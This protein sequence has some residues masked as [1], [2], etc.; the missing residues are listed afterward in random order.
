MNKRV[1]PQSVLGLFMAA[2]LVLATMGCSEAPAAPEGQPPKG[3]LNDSILA[4]SMSTS[5]EEAVSGHGSGQVVFMDDAGNLTSIE[6]TGIDGAQVEAGD[7]KLFFTD[8]QFDYVLTKELDKYRHRHQQYTQE[9]LVA[10]EGPDSF[11]A[12]FNSNYS[13]DGSTYQFDISSGT[14]KDHAEY[15]VNDYFELLGNCG[16]EIYGVAVDDSKADADRAPRNLVQLYPQTDGKGSTGTWTPEDASQQFGWEVPCQ[17]QQLH[18]LSTE[19]M[20][21]P[22]EQGA[23]KFSSIQLRRWDTS[24]GKL[25]SVPLTNPEGQL[26]AHQ[27]DEYRYLKMSSWHVIGEDFFWIDGMGTVFRTDIPTGVTRKVFK[28]R[29]QHN[30]SA[31]N[32]VEFAGNLV[33]VLDMGTGKGERAILRTYSLLTGKFTGQ[34][35]I[36]GLSELAAQS[37]Q[38]VHDFAI[39]NQ[40]N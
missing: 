31:H 6:T 40:S 19:L 3:L 32:H 35:V 10:L 34:T 27:N 17:G 23:T 21:D 30:Q 22:R 7:D 28:L 38:T 5:F 12:V 33:H 39:L 24:S 4:V 37:D 13:A 2:C 26:I 8:Q 20:D 15:R 14:G 16:D 9:L 36:D 11:A 25:S 18:F 29:L 1:Q